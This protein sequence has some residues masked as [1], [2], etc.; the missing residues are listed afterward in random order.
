MTREYENFIWKIKFKE[1]IFDTF[2]NQVSFRVK[3]W[4]IFRRGWLKK[5]FQSDAD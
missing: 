2:N 5:G 3:S 4:S 1:F